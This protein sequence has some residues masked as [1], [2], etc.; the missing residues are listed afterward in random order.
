MSGT[1][2]QARRVPIRVSHP[3]THSRAST[4]THGRADDSRLAN[5]SAFAR[6]DDASTSASAHATLGPAEPDAPLQEPETNGQLHRSASNPTIKNCAPAPGLPPRPGSALA[7]PPEEALAQKTLPA[8][9]GVASQPEAVAK[10]LPADLPK[11]PEPQ[12][13]TSLPK[14]PQTTMGPSIGEKRGAQDAQPPPAAKKVKGGEAEASADK[15]G[16]PKY[17]RSL[18]TKMEGLKKKL[19]ASMMKKKAEAAAKAEEE[20]EAKKAAD[21]GLGGTIKDSTK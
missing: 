17:D 1:N 15:G 16:V 9:P 20:E 13:P 10:A 4:S 11:K 21:A 19:Q 14:T 3:T 12:M 6:A 18:M 8:S 2:E 5:T 7:F